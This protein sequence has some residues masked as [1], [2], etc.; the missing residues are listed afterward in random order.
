[1][2]PLARFAASDGAEIFLKIE[3]Q[4]PPILLLHEWA[5]SHRVWEGIA[6]RLAALFTIYRWDARG[7]AAHDS[8][9]VAAAD[10]GVTL[11]RMA[12]DLADLIDHYRLEKP[13]VVGHS[14]GALILLAHIARHG[15]GRIGRI[16]ILDQ[17]P[18]LVTDA[19]WRLGIYGDWSRERDDHF[20]AAMKA[21]FVKAV[22]ELVA[23][24]LNEKAR[25]R[26]RSGHT[27][28][29]RMRTYLAMLD[30]RP[31]IAVWG[32]LSSADMRPILAT[33]DTPTLLIYGTESNFY[34][35]P[36]GAFV[37]DAITGAALIM[38]EGADHSPHINQPDRFVADLSRFAHRA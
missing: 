17:S 25:A 15:C 2:E 13:I 6:H 3:G 38:Y 21:D 32:T 12:D 18:R 16:C 24:G 37:K 10:R 11:A 7:H 30:P 19:T 5:S 35:P 34:P 8:V 4:G 27:G 23:F 26:Y 31:L 28:I 33:I 36:T 29:E 1:M 14:M 9:H 22:V 20:V